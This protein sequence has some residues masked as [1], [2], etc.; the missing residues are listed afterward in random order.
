[1]ETFHSIMN[2]DGN[3]ALSTVKSLDIFY[4]MMPKSRLE[5]LSVSE[6]Y[7]IAMRKKEFLYIVSKKCMY[8]VLRTVPF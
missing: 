3:N 2:V 4:Q 5:D 6:P 8:R 1:M 7:K